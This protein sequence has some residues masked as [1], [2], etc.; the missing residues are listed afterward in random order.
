[1]KGYGFPAVSRDEERI[2]FGRFQK[3]KLPQLMVFELDKDEGKPIVREAGFT[4]MAV[5]R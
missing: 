4:G 3:G 2:M 1:M 5:W